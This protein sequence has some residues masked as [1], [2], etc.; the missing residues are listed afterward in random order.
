MHRTSNAFTVLQAIAAIAA[1]AIT[2]WSLGLPSLRFAE[3][4]NVTSFSVTLSDSAP[5]APANHTVV[6]TVPS[7][8]DAGETIT[9][10]FPA[11]QFGNFINIDAQDIDLQVGVTDQALANGAASGATWGVSTSSNTIS[12]ESGTEAIAEDET[13]TI[14]I[15]T[16]A[17]FGGNGVDRITNPATT[18]SYEIKVEVG[19][20]GDTGATRVFIIDEVLVSATVE[21]IFTFEVTGVAD[22]LDL[23]GILTDVQT[24]ATSVPFGVLDDT[25]AV[26]AAQDLVV[27]TNAASGFVVTVQVDQ[28]LT[29][30]SGAIIHAFDNGSYLDLD[31]ADVWAEPQGLI[32]AS[33]TWGHWG[34]TSTDPSVT[35][36]LVDAYGSGDN[37]VAAST[38][39]VEVFRH[40]GPANGTTVGTGTTRVGYRAEVSALQ[41]AGEYTAT[42]TYVATPVF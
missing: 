23:G 34:L 15:G 36:G 17:T 38:T 31:N 39:P 29:S 16:N 22:G 42:L 26:A 13:V 33:T 8:M 21:T 24:T 28:Q 3:A 12:L 20:G 5:S 27:S 37:Y 35:S 30:N 40:D 6:F 10:E 32:A 2:L 18:T 14:L 41:P 1:L 7:G 11:G 25:G 4:A 9:I 19:D